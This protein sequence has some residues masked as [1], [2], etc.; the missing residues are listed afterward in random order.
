MK[1]IKGL[2]H[3]IVLLSYSTFASAQVQFSL[4]SGESA[5][6]PSLYGPAGR[7]GHVSSTDGDSLYIFGGCN[8]N[9]LCHDDLW[10]FSPRTNSWTLVDASGDL[11]SARAG[12]SLIH[13]QNALILFG[14][15][16]NDGT[17][18]D[19]Y[20]FDL[21]TYNWSIGVTIS[22]V[23]P[24]SRSGHAATT[25]GEKIYLFSGYNEN[26]K[27]FDDMWIVDLN[28]ES[29]N[30]DSNQFPVRFHPVDGVNGSPR[31]REAGTLTYVSGKLFLLGG[32]GTEGLLSNDAWVY[33]IEANSW[34]QPKIGGGQP[35]SRE[36][37]TAVRNGSNILMIGGCD[38]TRNVHRC[39][40]DVWK[41][42]TQKMRW[43][44]LSASDSKFKPRELHTADILSGGRVVIF[45]GQKLSSQD[46]GDLIMFET[47]ACGGNMVQCS[48]H[49][50]CIEGECS[51]SSGWS[52]HD[53][54]NVSKCISDCNNR[55]LCMK[56]VCQ[57]LPGFK[58]QS[59]YSGIACPG[60]GL[61]GFCN[62]N[63]ECKSDGI[64]ICKEGFSG[65][66]C[67][68][69]ASVNP[70]VFQKKHNEDI[71]TL[72]K[73]AE[74]QSLE[75]IPNLY[76]SISRD[77]KQSIPTLKYE[78]L[79]DSKANFHDL[80]GSIEDLAKSHAAESSWMPAL[81]PNLQFPSWEVES[82]GIPTTVKAIMLFVCVASGSLTILAMMHVNKLS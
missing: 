58:G 14:G 67:Q 76:D 62:G 5:T 15:T 68:F 20:K 19:I 6:I 2:I 3:L 71:L 73:D 53:C 31:G 66:G 60:S 25:D 63:G 12:A 51:C 55:G 29:E 46:Y 1:H 33:D 77:L 13:L 38:P 17:F 26:G 54:G 36:G 59:C 11:P 30:L 56:G 47:D 4:L 50:K 28:A 82:S 79:E 34:S 8:V 57:C 43:N 69:G 32:Y 45:G 41:L 16:N 80:E 72:E 21:K 40:N 22:D 81:L 10:K 48:G 52:S 70:K 9:G 18:N 24:E 44:L 64:C 39:F 35:N 49:G 7:H 23:R 37:H 78:A 61:K 27:Y 65:N 42:D 74:K 75:R